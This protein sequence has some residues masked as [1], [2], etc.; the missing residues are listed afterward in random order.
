MNNQP[1]ILRI[2]VSQPSALLESFASW[3][4]LSREELREFIQFELDAASSDK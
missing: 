1:N 4:K 2:S 3:N